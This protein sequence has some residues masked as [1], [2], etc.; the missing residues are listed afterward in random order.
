LSFSTSF[1]IISYKLVVVFYEYSWNF[2]PVS[3]KTA[4]L[5]CVL[6]NY[7]LFFAKGTKQWY[8][9]TLT[10]SAKETETG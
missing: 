2:S 5:Y 8:I 3:L 1:L 4:C 10:P 6:K 9:R 7:Q